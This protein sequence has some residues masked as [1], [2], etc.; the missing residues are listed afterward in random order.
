[1]QGKDDE[2]CPKCQSEELFVSMLRAGHAPA[3]LVLYPGEDHHFLGE[4]APSVRADAAR[5]V[6]DWLKR[7][8]SAR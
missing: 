5:R 6:V 8:A 4:G 1:M 7:H 2:R 3:E